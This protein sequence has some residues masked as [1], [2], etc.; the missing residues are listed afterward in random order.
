LNVLVVSLW[1]LG[2]EVRVMIVF[3]CVWLMCGVGMNVCSRVLIDVYGECLVKFVCGD[4][5]FGNFGCV[6]EV[7]IGDD[8]V[9]V[10]CSKG[11]C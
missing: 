7:V 5:F 6:F 8:Y 10:M 3:G 9:C 4:D 11:V 2:L 1:F